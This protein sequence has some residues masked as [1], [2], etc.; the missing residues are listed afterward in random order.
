MTVIIDLSKTAPRDMDAVLKG[1]LKKVSSGWYQSPAN[2][3]ARQPTR[4]M[5]Y[6]S[7]LRANLLLVSKCGDDQGEIEHKGTDI[8]GHLAYVADL[9]SDLMHTVQCHAERN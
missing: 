9:I 6:L 1:L 5:T 7:I 2:D 8:Q 3:P 4:Y